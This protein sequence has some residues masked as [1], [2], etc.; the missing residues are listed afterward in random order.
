MDQFKV[1][2]L[3]SQGNVVKLSDIDA[4]KTYLQVGVFQEGNRQK[5]AGNAN[6]YAPYAIA[7]S[8]I[9]NGGGGGTGS[10]GVVILKTTV[11]LTSPLNLV[12]FSGPGLYV[13][14]SALVTNASTDLSSFSN[15]DMTLIRPGNAGPFL[16]SMSGSLVPTDKLTFLYTPANY[17]DMESSGLPTCWPPP[18]NGDYVL[19]GTTSQ[20][21]RLAIANPS[22]VPAFVD[23]YIKLLKIA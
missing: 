8:E 12:P 2:S 4:D 18:C 7:V 3:I 1:Q 6:T 10:T 16:T 9:S 5:G 23:V 17:I 15:M 20:P 21:I 22:P 11:D 19:D 14:E 13:I